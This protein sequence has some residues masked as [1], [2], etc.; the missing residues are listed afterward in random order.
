LSI[1]CLVAFK[2]LDADNDGFVSKEEFSAFVKALH[3]SLEK[4]GIQNENLSSL[5]YLF[6]PSKQ[7]NT[8]SQT[9]SYPKQSLNNTN[10]SSSFISR[11]IPKA[12]PKN[13]VQKENLI[14]PL[15][16]RP[17]SVVP[18]KNLSALP[19][20]GKVVSAPPCISTQ[21][22][23][24][25]SLSPSSSPSPRPPVAKTSSPPTPPLNVSC[26][27]NEN[28]KIDL[29]QFK[30]I[31]TR[32]KT[33]IESLGRFPIPTN[34]NTDV[35]H[36][37]NSGDRLPTQQ[38][39]S[40]SNIFTD[41]NNIVYDNQDWDLYRDQRANRGLFISFG[42]EQWELAQYILLGLWKLVHIYYSFS[43]PFICSEFTLN[44]ERVFSTQ[45]NICCDFSLQMWRTCQKIKTNR[46]AY[47]TP[48]HFAEE[49]EETL[50][51]YFTI[52]NQI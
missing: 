47:L 29:D 7:E 48:P 6:F 15:T 49:V 10:N 37:S 52:H 22:V 41:V 28:L 17:T 23:P 31:A 39:P 46:I 45:S 12:N 51:M 27:Q 26:S 8:P 40:K 36:N 33:V 21:K 5:V 16:V 18:P 38:I 25:S 11:A 4:L 20:S 19:K 2:L 50:S 44:V 13:S 43:H 32:Y 34:N 35:T 1:E 9:S 30:S 14:S 24:S 42:N 3:R